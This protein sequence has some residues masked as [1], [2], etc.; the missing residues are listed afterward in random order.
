MATK[1]AIVAITSADSRVAIPSNATAVGVGLA[2]VVPFT[3]KLP[4]LVARV[5]V[6]CVAAGD[7]TPGAKGVLLVIPESA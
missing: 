5:L 1:A 7:V 6:V 2:I 3:T 4:G